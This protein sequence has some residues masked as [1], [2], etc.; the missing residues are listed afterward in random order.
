MV[1]KFGST[2]LDPVVCAISYASK[3]FYLMDSRPKTKNLVPI[4][5]KWTPPPVSW[6]K[7]NND[8][9]ILGNPGLAGGGGVIR[10]SLGN[11]V[12]GFSRSIGI[13]VSLRS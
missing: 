7:L 9:L 6:A 11:W 4:S 8:G 12:G 3:F 5:V 13:T 2:L 10:D 1:F